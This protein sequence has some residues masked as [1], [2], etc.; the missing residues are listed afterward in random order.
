MRTDQINLLLV[1]HLGRGPHPVFLKCTAGVA[2]KPTAQGPHGPKTSSI[3]FGTALFLAASIS[4]VAAPAAACT[5]NPTPTPAPTPMVSGCGGV[6][7]ATDGTVT[8]TSATSVEFELT[9]K[10]TLVSPTH[11][12][13][14]VP[15]SEVYDPEEEAQ[16]YAGEIMVAGTCSFPG[17]SGSTGTV[18]FT[19]TGTNPTVGTSLSG[20]G[21]GTC[22]VT[23]DQASGGTLALASTDFDS[24]INGHA[25][26][27]GNCGL[28]AVFKGAGAA[29]NPVAQGEW[30]VTIDVAG[31]VPAL[32]VLG[33]GA[34]AGVLMVGGV[35]VARR[36]WKP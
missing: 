1:H 32:S 30:A 35:L 21:T 3:F 15:S 28:T 6:G 2:R 10:G 5:T 23:G 11:P 29:P 31:D 13:S 22:V 4:L 20:T 34:V 9:T 25:A 18:S 19:M 12:P 7:A 24:F 8:F 17:G 14:P 26:M 33:L 36:Q 16:W 27:P